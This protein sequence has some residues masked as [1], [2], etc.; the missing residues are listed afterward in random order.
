M[1]GLNDELQ[2]AVAA[3]AQHTGPVLPPIAEPP[4]TEQSR[5]QLRGETRE[6][7]LS[8][9]R[10][11]R[12]QELV[13]PRLRRFQQQPGSAK[14]C[15]D[16]L[17]VGV[18]DELDLHLDRALDAT[19]GAVQPKPTPHALRTKSLPR[20][21]LIERAFGTRQGKSIAYEQLGRRLGQRPPPNNRIE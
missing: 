8:Q 16:Q 5:N 18:E 15:P 9:L 17:P 21:W 4:I 6:R 13:L 20:S 19:L 1:A 12:V 7:F 10:V 11:I 2:P 14:P 3:H